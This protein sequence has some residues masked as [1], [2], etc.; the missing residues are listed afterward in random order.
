MIHH[1]LLFFLEC[2]Q[3]VKILNKQKEAPFVSSSKR[4]RQEIIDVDE[5][6]PD[7]ANTS[8]EVTEGI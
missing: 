8:T 5:C 1:F 2:H 6:P 4:T 3:F 7:N